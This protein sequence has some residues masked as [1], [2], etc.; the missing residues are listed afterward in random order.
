[1]WKVR[2]DKEISYFIW[3]RNL[4]ELLFD[5]LGVE[6][7]NTYWLSDRK[8]IYHVFSTA[9]A[10]SLLDLLCS[11]IFILT[12][13][14]WHSRN[15][16]FLQHSWKCSICL[17]CFSSPCFLLVFY[18]LLSGLNISDRWNDDT[19]KK[20]VLLFLSFATGW[21]QRFLCV[22]PSLNYASPGGT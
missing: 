19:C 16:F 17:H 21:V 12:F 11:L 5:V 4:K 10:S 6:V 2:Q 22:N 13:N 18:F 9:E 8:S 20:G 14:G 1:M 15:F 7:W 3:G